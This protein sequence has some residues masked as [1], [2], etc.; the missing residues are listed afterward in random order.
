MSVILSSAERYCEKVGVF[1]SLELPVEQMFTYRQ[2]ERM[3]NLAV[4][5][6][7]R[8]TQENR[9]LWVGTW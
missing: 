8:Q 1:A 6:K 7:D 9:L 2:E 4:F 3:S 5:C